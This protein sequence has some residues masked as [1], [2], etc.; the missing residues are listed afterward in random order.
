MAWVLH[1]FIKNLHDSHMDNAISDCGK[2][3]PKRSSPK[4]FIY[5]VRYVV[6]YHDVRH[7]YPARNCRVVRR[8]LHV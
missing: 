7:D 1:N 4:I 8:F 6:R 3:L 5:D 2:Y